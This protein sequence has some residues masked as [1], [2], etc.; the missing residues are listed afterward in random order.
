M[1]VCRL[2]RPISFYPSRSR[3]LERSAA[4]LQF[5]GAR[6]LSCCS[7]T[8]FSSARVSASFTQHTSTP[9]PLP[10]ARQC[11]KI[12]SGLPFC[13]KRSVRALMSL[14]QEQIEARDDREVKLPTAR[15]QRIE[16]HY[17]LLREWRG[18]RG[19]HGAGDASVDESLA[20][21]RLWACLGSACSRLGR[22][23]GCRFC[24]RLCGPALCGRWQ[25]RPAR[26][27]AR[28]VASA[29]AHAIAIDRQGTRDVAHVRVGPAS[30][31]CVML[32]RGGDHLSGGTFDGGHGRSVLPSGGGPRA[33]MAAQECSGVSDR[34]A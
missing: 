22:R 14:P 2:P 4:T 28:R 19:R 18:S 12:R 1:E 17:D 31:K 6:G 25:S 34:F 5:S 16:Y 7:P 11:S 15:R 23:L 10:R 29:R 26:A 24:R 33:C 3:D 21:A 32:S 27:R 8:S 20:C 13:H 9:V 30:T